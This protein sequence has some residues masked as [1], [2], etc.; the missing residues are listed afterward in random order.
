MAN[1]KNNSSAK[2]Q[3]D[4]TFLEKIGDQASHLKD[5]LIA[6]KDHLVEI[7][8]EKIASVKSSIQEFKDR[9]KTP[10]RK[11]AVKKAAV[12]RAPLK[13]AAKKATKK[14]TKKVT[15]VA[16]GTLKKVAKKAVRV[17]GKSVVVKK[18]KSAPAKKTSKK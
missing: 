2:N 14:V 18:K 10:A 4:K 7:A 3:H 8:G 15:P 6:G 11:S 17:V 16:K 13:N 12:K 9:K 1:K 5:E